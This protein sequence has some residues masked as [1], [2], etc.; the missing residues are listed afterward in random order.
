[1]TAN[2][3]TLRFLHV[4]YITEMVWGKFAEKLGET[5]SGCG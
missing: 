5:T 3:V 4:G 2:M 1:M